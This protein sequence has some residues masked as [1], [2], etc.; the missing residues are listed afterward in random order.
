MGCLLRSKLGNKDPCGQ[1]TCATAIQ[2][3]YAERRRE[4]LY[5][6]MEERWADLPLPWG[7][8]GSVGFELATGRKVTTEVS[9]LD[10]VIRAKQRIGLRGGQ[11]FPGSHSRTRSKG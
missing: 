1:R 3:V 11:I 4:E 6:A 5:V 7:P 2:T 9:D 8:V 10:I